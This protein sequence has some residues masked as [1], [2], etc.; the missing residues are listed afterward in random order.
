MLEDS[1]DYLDYLI[2]GL[3]KDAYD[4]AQAIALS[5]LQAGDILAQIQAQ[6]TALVNLLAN[7]N[8]SNVTP[9]LVQQFLNGTVSIEQF[10]TAVGKLT[11]KEKEDIQDILKELPNLNDQL[12][13][14]RTQAYERLASI[15]EKMN[16]EMQEQRDIIDSMGGIA[17]HYGNII[18]IVGQDILGVSDELLQRMAD[19]QVTSAQGMLETSR[20]AKE[21]LESDLAALQA[22]RDA[23]S[24]ANSEDAKELDKQI[25][26]TTAKL[27]DATEQ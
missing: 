10:M 8:H 14:L 1:I 27:R 11:D 19:V 20:I 5:G 15:I 21:A 22:R 2:K 25:A 7:E 3:D 4:S 6:R 13:Q 18:D 24:D 16:D 26:E 23:I 17:K 12:N 9:E